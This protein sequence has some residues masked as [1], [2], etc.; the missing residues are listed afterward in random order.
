VD[1]D[2][3]NTLRPILADNVL[4]EF[5]YNLAWS[6][7][8]SGRLRRRRSFLVVLSST[9]LAHKATHSGQMYGRAPAGRP[10]ISRFVIGPSTSNLVSVLPL[11]Q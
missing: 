1:T 4:I 3:Q 8:L 9:I 5:L 11:E 2:G 10:F 7:Q 6:G